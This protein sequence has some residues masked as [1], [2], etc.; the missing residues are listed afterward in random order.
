[1][2]ERFG[3]YEKSHT[4]IG[5]AGIY[6]CRASCNYEHVLKVYHVDIPWQSETCNFDD[7]SLCGWKNHGSSISWSQQ[8]GRTQSSD[9][10]DWN[11]HTLGGTSKGG[12]MQVDAISQRD[13]DTTARLRSH[14]FP[15]GLTV[16]FEFWYR[17]S[18]EGRAI[19]SMILK[20]TCLSKETE[21]LQITGD[22]CQKWN[23]ATVTVLQNFVPND[24]NIALKADIRRSFHG[25]MAIDDVKISK[26]H[27]QD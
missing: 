13:T 11:S 6:V 20:D 21:L 1:M 3:G 24:Y 25:T 4:T 17:I 10:E 5:D 18:G 22:E 8:Y 26:G 23:K 12:Y 9:S 7:K 14:D 16:C 27:C 19:L 15:A 2:S